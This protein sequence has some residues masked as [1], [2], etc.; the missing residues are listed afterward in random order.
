[1]SLKRSLCCGLPCSIAQRG[2][3]AETVLHPV[4]WLEWRDSKKVTY[5]QERQFSVLAF[6]YTYFILHISPV[7]TLFSFV[8]LLQWAHIDPLFLG[9]TKWQQL[10]YIECMKQRETVSSP[11]CLTKQ[12]LGRDGAKQ[13][14]R[15]GSSLVWHSRK[16]K[17]N[18]AEQ[19]SRAFFPFSPLH[20]PHPINLS[21]AERSGRARGVIAGH[22]EQTV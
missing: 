11:L 20:A 8:C 10:P 3:N 7:L 18:I 19:G 6:S 14:G 1:M 5:S 15:Q 12:Y 22:K 13:K 4:V 2:F 21:S 17:D 16:R 9:I